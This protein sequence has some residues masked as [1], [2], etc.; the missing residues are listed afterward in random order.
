MAVAVEA[1]PVAVGRTSVVIE[2]QPWPPP[3]EPE[4]ES[5]EPP[6]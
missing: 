4:P 1:I 2:D 3:L 5:S 6:E